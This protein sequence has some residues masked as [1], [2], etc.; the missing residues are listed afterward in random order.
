MKKLKISI[1]ILTIV[2]GLSSCKP[3]EN[4]E[5]VVNP[6]KVMVQKVA[7]FEKSGQFQFPGKVKA[8][9]KL[10]L[11]TKVIGQVEQV[12]VDNGE[13][14]KKGQL[15]L[16]IRSNDISSQLDAA[17][18]SLT[19]AEAALSNTQKNYERIKRLYDK[20]S[21][22]QKEFDDISTA[23]EIGK[24]RTE[25]VNQSIKE[26]NELLRYTNLK[27]PING[28]VS[29]KF[30]NKGTMATPG[31]PLIMLESLDN[32]K[33]EITVPEFEIGLFNQGD[34]VQIEIND[35]G[36]KP[37]EGFVEYI[38]PSTSFS[39]TQYRVI[40]QLKENN[41][42]LKPGMF[43]RVNLLKNTERKIIVP[44]HALFQRGQLSGIYT[45]NQQGEAMLRWIRLGKEYPE[46]VE[47]LSGL[48]AG[49]QFILSSESKLTDGAKVEIT[50]SI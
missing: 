48:E 50:K 40:V 34:S 14:V 6:L 5:E 49:E 28:F 19:E 12:Y 26:I 42:D 29:Q 8:D 24:A 46:G 37:L 31:N 43:A 9:D 2:L 30:V 36:K 45:V 13:T 22:T 38:V 1:W 10:T 17:K 27:S 35:I 41:K 33:I 25:S 44:Q 7:P 11:S 18:A 3:G 15:L 20:G 16:K 23:Q 21:A 47:V 4:K 32:L 39:G